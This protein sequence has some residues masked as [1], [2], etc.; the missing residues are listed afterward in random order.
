[1]QIDFQ[2]PACQQQNRLSAV[3]TRAQ[4]ACRDCGWS[5]ENA[6][7]GRPAEQT[8]SHCVICG[9]TDLWRQK[10]FPARLGLAL[11]AL[12]AVLST[13]AI[14]W[15]RPLIALGI[16]MVFALIDLLL[17]TFMGD[18]LVCYRCGARHR[19]TEIAESHPRFDLEVNERYRQEAKRLEQA[20]RSQS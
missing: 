19:K 9:C 20:Q 5:R 13:L 2:C 8:P 4:L 1:M 14:A 3:E 15:Y 17:Y 16:L 6:L 11:V 18:M 10:D 12:A 7:Q